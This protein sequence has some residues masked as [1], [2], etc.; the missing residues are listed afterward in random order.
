[1]EQIG[2]LGE[3]ALDRLIDRLTDRFGDGQPIQ[4]LDVKYR[5]WGDSQHRGQIPLPNR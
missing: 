3:G 4:W 5:G 2:A 1:L